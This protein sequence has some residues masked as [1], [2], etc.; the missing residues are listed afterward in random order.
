MPTHNDIA[1]LRT[2]LTRNHPDLKSF[3][4]YFKKM[5]AQRNLFVNAGTFVCGLDVFLL[6]ACRK[7]RLDIV[8]YFLKNHSQHF[9]ING[10]IRYL[11]GSLVDK[12]SLL[13]HVSILPYVYNDETQCM[14]SDN[15]LEW[16]VTTLLHVAAVEGYLDVVKALVTAGAHVDSLDCCSET[17]LLKSIKLS[18]EGTRVTRFLIKRGADVDRKGGNSLTA[19]MH[20]SMLKS[21]IALQLISLLLDAGANLDV[22]DSRGYTALHIAATEGNTEVVKHLLACGADPHFH[23]SRHLT[24]QVSP[25]PLHVADQATL[26]APIYH[27]LQSK[28]SNAKNHDYRRLKSMMISYEE[29]MSAATPPLPT[30]VTRQLISHP[31]CP[32]A[33]KAAGF[34]VEV[35][36][37]VSKWMEGDCKAP[38][39]KKC[40]AQLHEYLDIMARI[41]DKVD[42]EDPKLQV[43]MKLRELL[44]GDLSSPFDVVWQC[45]M[46]TELVGY[47]LEGTIHLMLRSCK[48]LFNWKLYR[49]ALLILQRA[50]LHLLS[51]IEETDYLL[52][53]SESCCTLLIRLI[54]TILH[55]IQRYPD[56]LPCQ[57]WAPLLSSTLTNTAGSIAVYSKFVSTTHPHLVPLCETE[58]LAK[59]V[60]D[61][62]TYW[63]ATGEKE[64]YLDAVRRL[65]DGCPT[66]FD[67][68]NRCSTLLHLALRR[69]KSERLLI[70]LLQCGGK[71]MVNYMDYTGMRPLHLAAYVHVE[72]PGRNDAGIT[73]SALLDYGAHV[74]AVDDG[75]LTAEQYLLAVADSTNSKLLRSLLGHGSMPSL[76]CLASHTITS[77]GI[78]YNGTKLP[79]HLKAYISCHDSH[80]N[81]LTTL[82]VV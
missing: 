27:L 55:F 26:L 62:V 1:E 73:F 32:S 57:T 68:K 51:L 40:T 42:E 64:K 22:T 53:G 56:K 11:R 13:T 72:H 4:T 71:N 60:L 74:D 9:D 63:I 47:G 7:G 59:G 49:E 75:G 34:L 23:T 33:C 69:K 41:G 76:M 20:A 65:V 70:I 25:S 29:Y 12:S 38:I 5:L 15:D 17:P 44:N 18:P 19:L 52:S 31:D 21:K 82:S 46:L 54:N 30:G 3:P 6:T 24:L 61:I 36:T 35:I 16:H 58:L 28:L 14:Y 45:L 10:R 77:Q 50:S 67:N 79:Q 39:I 66:V 80:A 37:T 8:R 48:C 78:D 43:A 2:K 81:K